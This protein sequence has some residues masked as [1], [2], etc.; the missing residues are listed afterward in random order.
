MEII[1]DPP[2]P[3]SLRAN[4]K[5]STFRRLCFY[6]PFFYCII[7]YYYYIWFSGIYFW[8]CGFVMLCFIR[9]MIQ[10]VGK[11]LFDFLVKISFFKKVKIMMA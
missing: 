7:N 2:G 5:A 6:F 11:H 3:G 4:N 10:V 1:Y 8:F 9:S